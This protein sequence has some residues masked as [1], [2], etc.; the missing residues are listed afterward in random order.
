MV[1]PPTRTDR[2]RRGTTLGTGDLDGELGVICR[3]EHLGGV[4]LTGV[5][6]ELD[7]ASLGTSL[8]VQAGTTSC[9]LPGEDDA[10]DLVAPPPRKFLAVSAAFAVS[11][12]TRPS[13]VT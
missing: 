8:T 6:G 11:F 13:M 12:R 5:P 10:A 7:E 3:G 9:S 4:L 1:R 2:G